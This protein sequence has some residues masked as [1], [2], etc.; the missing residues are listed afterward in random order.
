MSLHVGMC[1]LMKDWGHW[2]G[3]RGHNPHP[4]CRTTSPHLRLRLHVCD[5]TLRGRMVVHD[6]HI[7]TLQGTQTTLK[8][9]S[10]VQ[11]I[12]HYIRW[13]TIF[14]QSF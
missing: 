9:T 3:D 5:E 12:K 2:S 1:H 11:I 10:K 14:L 7:A 13:W 6:G 8:V 4:V